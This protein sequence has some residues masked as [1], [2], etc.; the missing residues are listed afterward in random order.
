MN[1]LFEKNNS[2]TR[3]Q[4]NNKLWSSG[5]D[6]C[7]QFESVTSILENY[8]QFLTI[9]KTQSTLQPK[10]GIIYYLYLS[11]KQ[12][13]SM[14]IIESNYIILTMCQVLLE[15]FSIIYNNPLNSE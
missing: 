9:N 6:C 13:L 7:E 2:D 12:V 5:D 14:I 1:V 3:F 11:V 15:V 10:L 4:L 8:R